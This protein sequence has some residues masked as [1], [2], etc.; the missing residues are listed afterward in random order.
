MASLS[1][2]SIIILLEAFLQMDSSISRFVIALLGGKGGKVLL[3]G[4]KTVMRELTPENP[5]KSYFR[6]DSKTKI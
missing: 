5:R 2:I 3:L 1:G 6:K 4:S